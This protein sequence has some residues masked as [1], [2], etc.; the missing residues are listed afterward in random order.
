MQLLGYK[1][2]ERNLQTPQAEVDL[3]LGR[4]NLLVLLEVKYRKTMPL[5][6]VEKKQRLRLLK[7]AQ[8][9]QKQSPRVQIPNSLT[10]V[11]I[12]IDIALVLASS[13]KWPLWNFRLYKNAINLEELGDAQ[14]IVSPEKTAPFF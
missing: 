1:I 13:G 10:E 6:L 11:G 2:L 3:L 7:A 4:D 5:V 9:I 14:L 8:W 12:R